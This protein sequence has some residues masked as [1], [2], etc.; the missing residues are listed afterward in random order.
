M[1]TRVVVSL[2]LVDGR[3]PSFSGPGLYAA[4]LAAMRQAARRD[5]DEG[6]IA[7]LDNMHDGPPPKPLVLTPITGDADGTPAFSR[8]VASDPGR[9]WRFEVGVLDHEFAG[10]LLGALD[11]LDTLYV[12]GADYAVERIDAT[13]F[14]YADLV[15]H[16]QAN[17]SWTICFRSPVTFGTPDGA[18][19]GPA[20]TLP[21]PTP[22]LVFGALLYRWHVFAEPG[23]LASDTADVIRAHLAVADAELRTQRHIVKAPSTWRLGSVGRAT[24]TVVRSKDVSGAAL[25]SVTA[26]VRFATLAG[27]GDFT[28]VGMGHVTAE[29][30]PPGALQ[31]AMGRPAGSRRSSRSRRAGR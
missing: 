27:V 9:H 14:G 15:E 3:P 7:R 1:L 18:D 28:T 24:Y 23:L 2:R 5:R 31:R 21:L 20:R 11:D 30:A 12:G 4:L 10:L 26:L 22:E 16:A 13:P 6:L 8:T 25:S 17:T 19:G 29:P